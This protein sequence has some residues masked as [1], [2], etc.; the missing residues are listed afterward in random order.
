MPPIKN[1]FDKPWKVNVL[2][3][4]CSF[5]I[6]AF[7]FFPIFLSINST[8]SS[9]TLD[10]LKNYYTFVYHIKN[11][12]NALA[13]TG[14]NYPFGEH[15]V[16][17][18]CQ[19]ILTFILR[20]FPFTHPYLIGIMHSLMF[21][22]FIITPLI[23]N[24]LFIRLGLDKFTSFF[25]SIALALLAP[26]FLKINA[27]H[28]ALAYGFIFPLSILLILDLLKTCRLKQFVFLLTFNT[29]LFFLHPY[30]GFCC[31][32]LSLISLGIFYYSKINKT[33]FLKE[34]LFILGAGIFPILFFK[35][36]MLITDTHENRTR[37]PFGVE[38]MLEN[39]DSI[40]SPVFGP[41]KSLM[42][43]FFSNRTQHY[44]GHTYL[45]FA[46]ILLTIILVLFTPFVLKKIKFDKSLLSLFIASLLILFVS[47]GW[48][49]AVLNFLGIQ[50]ASLNQFR[51][52]CR[53]AW[54]FYYTLPVFVIVT[55]Y[56][57]LKD[58]MSEKKFTVTFVATSLLF[59]CSNL[60]E[61]HYF[62]KLDS[63]SFWK[64]RNVFNHDQLNQEEQ[65]ILAKIKTLN[66]QALI[67]LP[68]FHGGSEMYDRLGSS[69]SMLPAMIYSFHGNIPILSVM[70]SRTSIT[71]TEDLLELLNS[72]K[73]E[74]RIGNQLKN[75][76]FFVIKTPDLLLPDETRLLNN[77][78]F[79]A[80][81]DSLSFGYISV[82]DLFSQKKDSRKLVLNTNVRHPA[83]SNNIIL[84]PFENRKPYIPANINDYENIFTLDSNQ[85]KSGRYIV[86]MHYHY[87]EKIFRAISSNLIITKTNQTTHEWQY[88]IP[89]RYLS[90]FYNGF[91]VFEYPIELSTQ[92]KYE[93]ILKG[94][95]DEPYHIS[96]FMLRP[97]H[98]TVIGV[99][100]GKDTLINNFQQ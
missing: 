36:F 63:S 4:I 98:T 15:V 100:Q 13:F 7:Y 90:G 93:F 49:L 79:F 97:E 14:M 83:D 58:R 87:T 45:G 53:F 21:L 68:V 26:Q 38:M 41:F 33:T 78:T 47:F 60:T 94:F 95:F 99:D 52:V 9:I 66:P 86:S 1:T 64:Y 11:D 35:I 77:V 18:D 96:H 23:L 16:Y 67:P 76:D 2:L 62:F 84:I 34:N 55:L 43:I 89:I 91:A 6:Y 74:K 48:H 20:L 71:E 28:F 81:H 37:E 30:L 44:E 59:F 72:Y 27:G 40:V 69:N 25:I 54:V 31:S 80:Q 51:A 73:K 42:E 5:S 29:L 22:S 75:T 56:H 61:A 82:K 8:L 46:S 85:L 32:I 50:S 39:I 88:N 24:K 3:L 17:T 19:P 70:L 92:N 57:T 10:S 65:N 12:I